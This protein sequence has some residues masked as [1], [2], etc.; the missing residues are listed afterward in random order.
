[1]I[2]TVAPLLDPDSIF[3]AAAVDGWHQDGGRVRPRRVRRRRCGAESRALVNANGR[4]V[5]QPIA[6]FARGRLPDVD[7]S[8]PS[9]GPAMRPHTRR[10]RAIVRKEMSEYRRNTNIIF[11]IAILLIFLIQ[12]LV[13]VFALPTSASVPLRHGTS[14]FTCWPS[15][16]LSP[17]TLGSYS[18]VGERLQGTL[19][20]VLGTPIRREDSCSARP[21]RRSS[22]PSAS[23][24]GLRLLRGRGGALRATGRGIRA[25]PRPGAARP[26]PV[27][28]TPGRLVHLG[29]HRRPA[30][31]SDPATQHRFRY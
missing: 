20:P 25:R 16:S 12:P 13:Q 8:G 1:M 10:V 19:E 24:T 4:I 6:A 11:A 14:C 31:S 2:K 15:Q 5:D 18:I 27:H 3:G 7:R 17:V 26:D 22:P 30:R 23:P 29:R 9:G 28:A 21:S